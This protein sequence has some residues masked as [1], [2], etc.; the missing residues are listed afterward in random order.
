M[1]TIMPAIAPLGSL[2]RAAPSVGEVVP[3]ELIIVGLTVIAR[4]VVKPLP[5]KVVVEPELFRQV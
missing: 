5:D 1:P 4:K 3:P 2:E